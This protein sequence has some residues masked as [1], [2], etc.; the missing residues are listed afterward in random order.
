MSSAAVASRPVSVDTI[1]IAGAAK[2]TSSRTAWNSSSIGSI[3]GE[4]NAWLTFSRDT[5]RPAVRHRSATASTSA[6]APETTT[7]AGPF[8]AAMP[9]V[10]GRPGRTSASE[11][12]IAIIAPPAGSACMSRPRADTTRTASPSDQ[13]PA[14]WAAASSPIE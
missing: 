12:W 5:F 14:T 9:V 7:E 13:R 2:V 6:V 10:S 11:A 4:W 3:S 1:G 8:T